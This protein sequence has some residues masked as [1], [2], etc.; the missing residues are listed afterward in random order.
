MDRDRLV[1]GFVSIG[2]KD[3]KE[4]FEI[5]RQQQYN[6]IRSAQTEADRMKIQYTVQAL[7][8]IQFKLCKVCDDKKI[9][10]DI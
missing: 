8:S 10:L 4:L 1:R 3:L 7:D 5:F 9:V 6:Q 2:S